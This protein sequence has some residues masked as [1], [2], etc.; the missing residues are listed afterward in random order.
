MRFVSYNIQYGTGKDGRVDLDRIAAEIGEADVIALQEVDR[1][2]TRSGKLDQAAEIAARFADFH[3]AFGAGCDVDASFRDTTGRLVNRRR[4]FGNMLLARTPIMSCR[5]HLLPKLGLVEQLGIQRSALEG[6]IATRFGPIR[7]YAVHLGHAAA[8]ERLKQIERLREIVASAPLAGGVWS[9]RNYG[10]E[11]E[12]DGPPPPMP[13]S[14]VLL[15][16][17][18]CTPD[19]AEYELLCGAVE[20]HYGR[21]STLDGLM[22]CWTAAGNELDAGPTQV[23]KAG[24]ARVDY[25]LATPDLADKVTAMTVDEAARGSDHQPIRVEIAL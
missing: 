6:V 12:P 17:F 10:P 9:G 15:G 19:S 5:N 13:D 20:P 4:Q 18:N 2:W 11:W 8:P 25:A 22:D 24:P 3:W 23:A 1:F 14:A 16:D 21:L 7:V